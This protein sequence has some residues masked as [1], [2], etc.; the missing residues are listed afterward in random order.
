MDG[1][2]AENQSSPDPDYYPKCLSHGMV[3]LCLAEGVDEVIRCKEHFKVKDQANSEMHAEL[4]GL[5]EKLSGMQSLNRS[6]LFDQ[7]ISTCGLLSRL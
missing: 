6:E 2:E 4:A 7:D 5:Q 3:K 1:A